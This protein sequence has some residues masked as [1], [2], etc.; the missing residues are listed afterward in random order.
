MTDQPAPFIVPRCEEAIDIIYRDDSLLLVNKPADLLS[1][2]GKHPQNQDCV[3]SRLQ[4]DFRTARIVHRLDMATSGIMVIALT[5][6]SHRQLSRQFE[7]RQTDKHYIAMVDGIVENDAGSIELPIITDWPNRP[8]QKVCFDTGKQAKTDYQ[9]L[10]RDIESQQTRVLLKPITGRSHQLR[11]HMA[12]I[13]HPILGCR[14]YGHDKAIAKSPRLLLHAE[15][16]NFTHPDTGEA[17]AGLS[18]CPF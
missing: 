14:F 11:I 8:L 12:E 5:S 2:P 4:Q 1:V 7:L 16:L 9:V 17:I 6:D 15:K 13:G 3:I 18:P 10:A